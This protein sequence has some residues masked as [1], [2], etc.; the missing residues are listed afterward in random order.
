[1]TTALPL[2]AELGRLLDSKTL[3]SGRAHRIAKTTEMGHEP[4][5]PSH[6]TKCRY[7]EPLLAHPLNRVRGVLLG[8]RACASAFAVL[9]LDLFQLKAA[10]TTGDDRSISTA[11]DQSLDNVDLSR[12]VRRDF[13][14][15]FLLAY[16]GLCPSLHDDLLS[17][18]TVSQ[19]NHM[20]N[21][22]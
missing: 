6:S 22:A 20:I 17:V 19:L 9:G 7:P 3:A 18:K 12:Q 1:M 5:S 11:S 13:E 16:G 21:C 14:A 10:A 8:P 15:D 2:T 4:P